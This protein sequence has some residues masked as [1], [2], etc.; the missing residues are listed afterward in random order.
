MSVSCECCVLTRRDFWDR[1]RQKPY[2]VCVFVFVDSLHRLCFGWS[3]WKESYNQLETSWSN[4]HMSSPASG[5]CRKRCGRDHFVPIIPS[6]N[7]FRNHHCA[8]LPKYH[9][10]VSTATTTAIAVS[11]MY[12]IQR[13]PQSSCWWQLRLILEQATKVKRKSLCISILFL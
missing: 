12:Y 1:R 11:I 10:A 2:R 5:H 13:P 9:H 4:I 8:L 7:S 3:E 6:F